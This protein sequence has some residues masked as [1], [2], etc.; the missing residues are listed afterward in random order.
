MKRA[1]KTK[2]PRSVTALDR[3]V[4]QL[5][6]ILRRRTGDV[7]RAG[8]LL[9]KA[10]ALFAKE[11]GEWLPW[12]ADNFDLSPRTAQRYVAAAEYVQKRHGV[13]FANLSASVLYRLAEGDFDERIEAAILAEARKRRVEEDTMWAIC[14][15]FAAPDDDAD[16]QEDSGDDDDAEDAA[17]DAESAAILDGPPPA[18]SPPA[19]IPG[20]PDFVLREFDQAIGTLKKLMTKQC[21]QFARTTHSA[22]DLKH[23]EDFIHGVTK[24][25]RQRNA[26]PAE[27]TGPQPACMERGR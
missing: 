9:I 21:G 26:A 22:D 19:P 3:I 12:L 24:A 4:T 18:V 8:N 20:S 11:H 14:E 17:E 27:Q 16:D 7:V 25:C 5:R 13:A 15:K 10:R 6:T 2:A 23:I 1:K